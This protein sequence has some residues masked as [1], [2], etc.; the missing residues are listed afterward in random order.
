[1]CTEAGAISPLNLQLKGVV[2]CL[3]KTLRT[4]FGSYARAVHPFKAESFDL[5]RD[6]LSND[7]IYSHTWCAP[8][9]FFSF[10]IT[11]NFLLTESLEC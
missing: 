5:P 2:S 9:M 7:M 8:T 6:L 11:A 10:N 3:A 4:K 1:M